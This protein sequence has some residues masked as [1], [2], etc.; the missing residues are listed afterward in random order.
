MIMSR[1]SSAVETTLRN[2]LAAARGDNVTQG[3]LRAGDLKTITGLEA[4]LQFL[5]AERAAL[6]VEAGRDPGA[7]PEPTV[8]DVAL[9]AAR[10]EAEAVRILGSPEDLEMHRQDAWR[11]HIISDLKTYP[12]TMMGNHVV[13]QYTSGELPMPAG[14]PPGWEDVEG[15]IRGEIERWEKPVAGEALPLGERPRTSMHDLLDR[16]AGSR[17]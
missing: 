2:A 15:K 5:E 14:W 10:V 6:L 13:K 3:K 4:R 12:C 16:I 8:D 17:M 9:A 1:G 11:E 7:P